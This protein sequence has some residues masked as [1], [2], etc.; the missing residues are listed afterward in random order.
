VAAA[1]AGA[2]PGA[3]HD[4]DGEAAPL[5]PL[6]LAQTRARLR[7][8]LNELRGL[9]QA[10]H[11]GEGDSGEGDE[12]EGEEDQQDGSGEDQDPAARKRA[13][14]GSGKS[15]SLQSTMVYRPQEHQH[16]RSHATGHRPPECNVL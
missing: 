3:A 9:Q 4:R 8:L 11:S 13:L 7:A 10:L 15:Q 6:N 2:A 1:P 14:Q 5:L 12:G 16:K